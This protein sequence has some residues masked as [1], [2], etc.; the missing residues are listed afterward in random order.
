MQPPVILSDVSAIKSPSFALLSPNC[1]DNRD[2]SSNGPV[3]PPIGEDTLAIDIPCA[4]GG[5]KDTG[6]TDFRE[7]RRAL[8]GAAR[9]LLMGQYPRPLV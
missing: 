3:H 5:E 8:R 4:I 6:L 7:G 1:L 2:T 9:S